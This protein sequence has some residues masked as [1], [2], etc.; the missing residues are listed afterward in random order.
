MAWQFST[1]T[2][3]NAGLVASVVGLVIWS[4]T[5]LPGLQPWN[6]STVLPKEIHGA[7]L[8]GQSLMRV[9]AKSIDLAGADLRRLHVIDGQFHDVDFA[10][11]N[12]SGSYFER[13]VF[14]NCDFR[15]A[16]LT[17]VNFVASKCFSCRFD[18]G[19]KLPFSLSLAGKFGFQYVE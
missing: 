17:A 19:T 4:Q 16:D 5:I 9:E 15:N 3:Q 14:W 2:F 8:L 18:G 6:Q 10:G 11:A 13:V 7:Q 12:L 1:R